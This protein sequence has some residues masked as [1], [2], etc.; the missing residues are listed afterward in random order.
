VVYD[1]PLLVET[2]SASTFDVV[3]VVD[4][5]PDEAVRRMVRD[6]GWTEEEA[7]AR[8]AAQ[9]TREDRR[10]AATYVIDNSGTIDE[11]RDRVE[12]IF[13]ELTEPRPEREDP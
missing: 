1:V 7:R 3:I 13:A 5:E 4:A 12:R 8:I 11:L 10:A 6:R 2:G 9:A